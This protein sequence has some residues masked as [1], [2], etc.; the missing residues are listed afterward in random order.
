MSAKHASEIN[1]PFVFIGQLNR[2]LY[3][4]Y[5]AGGSVLMLTSARQLPK[6][7]AQGKPPVWPLIGLP[8]AKRSTLT[9]RPSQDPL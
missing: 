4:Y 2:I 6:S 8:F 9:S 3:I 1:R 7:L 5:A